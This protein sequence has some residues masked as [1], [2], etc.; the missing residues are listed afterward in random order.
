M[1]KLQITLAAARVNAGM[2][3]ADVASKMH[4]SKN[5]ILNWEKGKVSPGIPELEMLCRMYKIPKDNIF[6]P[7]ILT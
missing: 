7:K 1:E 4:I 5:T 6:L 3:Q 2:T